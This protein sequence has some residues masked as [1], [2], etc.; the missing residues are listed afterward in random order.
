[1]PEFG[2]IVKAVDIGRRGNKYTWLPCPSCGS[3]RWVMLVNGKPRPDAQV[4][5]GCYLK[6]HGGLGNPNW[7]GGRILHHAGYRMVKAP[8]HPYANPSGY[9]FEHRLAMEQQLGRYLLPGEVVGFRDGDRR[10]TAPDNLILFASWGEFMKW[11]RQKA[12]ETG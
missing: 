9:V 1:M 7:K 4:C 10:N 3:P 11:R 8:G 6:R 5:R 12:L 2:E